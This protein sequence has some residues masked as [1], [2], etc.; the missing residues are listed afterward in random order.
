V[1]L[2][3]PRGAEAGQR[4]PTLLRIHG[5]PVGQYSTAF[6]EEWQMLAAHGYAVVAANPRGSS[7]YG[8]AFSKAIWS[9]WGNKDFEDVMAAV[10]AAVERGVADPDRLGVG[11]W[12][13]GGILTN[14]VI[15]R[16]D[17]FRG[18][19]SGASEVN[20][21]SNYGTDHYQY[22][23]EAEL[24][25]P[26]ENTEHWIRLSPFFRVV[27]V[28]TP[29]LILCGEQ[30]QNV[31]LLNSEQLYQALRRLGRE[32][33]LV[34][35]P[36]QTHGIAVPSYQVDR[37]ERYLGW[38]DRWV[39]GVTAADSDAEERPE[40]LL[41][42]ADSL[43]TRTSGVANGYRMQGDEAR[44]RA[45]LER[46]LRGDERPALGAAAARRQGSR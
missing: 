28:V 44:A 32:T 10:D 41:G 19:I 27:N 33:E 20:Y 31:P 39:K 2:T 38:Y 34:I 30:D 21:L 4:L 29:T 26:W 36:G 43:A 46:A 40:A 13:Y 3:S 18:A 12:S 15:T 11:G 45:L 42:P 35:Y 7:G 1:F 23:W 5:G 25:L 9:D 17:R 37:Y 16:T 8:E 14:Y 22:E 24:G 6:N